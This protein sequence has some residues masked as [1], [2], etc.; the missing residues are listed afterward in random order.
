MLGFLFGFNARLGRMHYFLATLG[1]AVV[2]TAICYVIA[3]SLIHAYTP[4]ALSAALLLK[5]PVLAA[6]AF[7]G[8]M[9]FTLQSMRIRDIGWDPV[10]VIPAWM[11]I[12]VVDHLVA[13]RIPSWS[14]DQDHRGTIIGAATNLVLLLVLMFWP[15]G[16]Y[17]G[18]TSTFDE[19]R[20]RPDGPLRRPEAT[21]T[22]AER[23]TRVTE[24]GF[25]R[26]VV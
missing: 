20:R 17:Q 9:T 12:L 26:R 1:L 21:S 6:M 2:M 24:G 8:W 14:L 15:S 18:P 10:C 13:G 16:D 3:S 19:P 4:G 23:V 11:A 22:A 5:W 25:G 7:F